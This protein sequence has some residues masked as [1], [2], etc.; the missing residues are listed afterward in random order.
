[1]QLAATY[2]VTVGFFVDRDS[3]T[4]ILALQGNPMSGEEL[5]LTLSILRILKVEPKLCPSVT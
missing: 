5:P 1:M 3:P 2:V 4:L